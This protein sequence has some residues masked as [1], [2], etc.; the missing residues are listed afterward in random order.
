MSN[1]H[2]SVDKRITLGVI[3]IIIGGLFLLSTLNVIDLRVP[4]II[5]SFPFILLIVGILIMLNSSKKAFGGIMA[6]IGF[7][8]LLPRIFPGLNYGGNVILPLLL[9]A[10]GIYIITRYS[11]KKKE[12]DYKTVTDEFIKKDVID[13]VAIFGGGNKIIRTDNFKG[14]SITSIFGGSEIDLTQ[15]KLAEG[16]NVIDIV[17]IFG[18]STIIVPKDWNVQTNVTPVFGGFSNKTIKTPNADVDT[19]RILVIKGLALFG[20]GE[21]KTFY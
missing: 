19:S 4:R 2:G 21:V 9:I 20:G 3:L 5:F 7:I 12:T 8:W 15:C 6:G 14:G 11:Q 18:G 13:D 17:A 1:N 10:L 16:N